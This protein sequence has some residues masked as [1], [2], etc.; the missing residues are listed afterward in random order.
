MDKKIGKR[1]KKNERR[2]RERERERERK[3]K[4]IYYSTSPLKTYT[5][6]RIMVK[7]IRKN[8]ITKKYI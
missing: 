3:E 6:N 1:K 5:I 7:K 2:E 4:T 8:K